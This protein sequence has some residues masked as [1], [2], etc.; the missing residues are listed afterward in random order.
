MS[1]TLAVVALV[2]IGVCDAEPGIY[3]LDSPGSI[4]HIKCGTKDLTSPGLDIEE[5]IDKASDNH[6]VS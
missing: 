6:C 5:K 1:K 3:G 4:C 2:I